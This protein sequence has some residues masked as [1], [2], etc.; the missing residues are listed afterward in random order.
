MDLLLT[1][2][3]ALAALWMAKGWL[4]QQRVALLAQYLSGKSIEKDIETLSK[5]YLP[6]ARHLPRHRPGS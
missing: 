5:G 6:C 1:L 2:A 4:Q 3:V